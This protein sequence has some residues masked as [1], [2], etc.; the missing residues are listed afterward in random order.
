MGL[1]E[2]VLSLLKLKAD[3][4]NY[5]CNPKFRASA[6]QALQKALKKGRLLKTGSLYKINPEFNPA[7]AV[8]P[9]LE[10]LLIHRT[11]PKPPENPKSVVL[12][13]SSIKCTHGTTQSQP[14]P[15]VPCKTPP[16]PATN[17]RNN[18][19]NNNSHHQTYHPSTPHRGIWTTTP[20][21]VVH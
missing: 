12:T 8:H 11:T 5:P 6:S 18:S 13:L 2:F 16:T 17:S 14:F 7:T 19:L 20:F 10:L 21:L 1:D 9:P 4:R 3:C 15:R